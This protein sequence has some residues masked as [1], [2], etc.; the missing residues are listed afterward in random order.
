MKKMCHKLLKEDIGAGEAGSVVKSI[1]YFSGG[2]RFGSQHSHDGFQLFLVPV[3]G[4][5][6]CSAGL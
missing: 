4:V 3:P 5:R 6:T 1:D 2:L